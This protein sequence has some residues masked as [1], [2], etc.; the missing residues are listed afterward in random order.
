MKTL[1]LLL[2]LMPLALCIPT[3]RSCP[4]GGKRPRLVA[5]EGCDAEPCYVQPGAT[6]FVDIITEHGKLDSLTN[7]IFLTEN[8]VHRDSGHYM[9]NKMFWHVAG[10]I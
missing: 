5:I 1:T 6:V 3:F 10:T 2:A 9:E 8:S 7:G 4:R